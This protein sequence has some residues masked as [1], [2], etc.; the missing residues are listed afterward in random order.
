[1]LLRE[2]EKAELSQLMRLYRILHPSDVPLPDRSVVEQRWSDIQAD[3]AHTY[4]GAFVD[5]S[6]VSTCTLSVI[7]NLTRG[8]RPYGMIE[9]VVTDPPFRRQGIG[10]AVLKHALRHAWKCECYKVM[11]LTGRLN[12]ETYRFYEGA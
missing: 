5:D 10:S 7:P 2:I 1:M 6:L 4:F 12:E 9:N 3:S 11:L 8:C